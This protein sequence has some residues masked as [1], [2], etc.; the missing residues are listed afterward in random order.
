M[1]K[2][3]SDFCVVLNV[4]QNPI[5]CEFSK[6]IQIHKICVVLS[7]VLQPSVAPCEHMATIKMLS[8]A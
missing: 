4:E 5:K 3:I 8:R 1:Q 7:M 2:H 6:F